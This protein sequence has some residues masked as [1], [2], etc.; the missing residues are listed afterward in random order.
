MIIPIGHEDQRVKRLPW[1]TI[2]LVI[3]NVAVF[4]LTSQVAQQQAA[5]TRARAQETLRYFA[6]HPHLQLPSDLR[7]VIPSQPLPADH[8]LIGLAEEQTKLDGMVREFR[9]SA[10]RNV[11]WKFGYI[12]AD[13]SLLALFTSMFLHGGWMHLLGNM[14]FLWLVGGSLEDRWGRV[15]FFVFYIASGVVA[16][17]IHGVMIPQSHVPM[18][19]AS[20]AIAGLMGAFLVRLATT[21][22]RFFYWFIIFRGTFTMPAYVALPFWLLQQFSMARSGAGGGIAVWAHIGG[23]LFGAVIALV[24]WLSGFEAKILVPAVARKTSWSAS[25]QLTAAL[26]MLDGGDADGGI[27]SLVAL[28]KKSPNNIEARATL[29]GA[30]AQ[31]G[32]TDSAGRESGRLVSAYLAARDMEGALAALEEHRRAHPD[33]APSMRSLLALAAYREKQEQY[34]EAADLYQRAIQAWPDDPLGPKALISY[35]RLILDVFHEPDAALELLEQA[36]A[37]PKVTPEFERVSQELTAAAQRARP[38]AAQEP[39]IAP[40]PAPESA[41]AHA[42]DPKMPS[43]EGFEQTAHFDAPPS[44]EAPPQATWQEEPPP[45][46]SPEPAAAG[47]GAITAQIE[48][49]SAAEPGL[50]E[51]HPPSAPAPEPPTADPSHGW[52][53]IEEPATESPAETVILPLARTLAP[54]SM[55]A[56]GI[57]ARGLRLKSR[58]GTTGVLQWQQI[59]GLST[60]RIADPASTEQAGDNLVLDLL[61][62]P[63]ST[64]D[65][66]VV[67][68]VRLSAQDLAIPQLQNE[69]SPLRG[70]QRFV[71]TALKASGATPHPSR[72][73]CLGLQGFATFPDLAAYEA[74]LL[75]RLA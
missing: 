9:A 59:I 20:G 31:K 40:M 51:P 65:G 69:P 34:A 29:V 39:E 4:I 11:Y 1:V 62:A 55:Q 67:R 47:W 58:G 63:E 61:M 25:E 49:P 64:P 8:S 41:P 70:F 72:E 43:I 27:R 2:A 23:F 73:E 35:A 57:D 52:L 7:N 38:A 46:A 44:E 74:A 21:R 30:Y 33:V 60:A 45:S 36:R 16:A 32:D 75:A 42:A 10:K 48:M 13:P 6:E 22:I 19:G 3:A 28:L 68:C 71:A 53:S 15:C 54:T 5:E 37:H 50:A 66:D 18:V 17:L 26:G 24:I 14:L 12:P 56:V